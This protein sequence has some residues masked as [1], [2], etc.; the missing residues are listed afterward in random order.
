MLKMK[1]ELMFRCLSDLSSL[2]ESVQKDDVTDDVTADQR[3]VAEMVPASATHQATPST[4]R[5]YFAQL[6]GKK[7]LRSEKNEAILLHSFY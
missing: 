6:G 5:D 2:R 1:N 3:T 7:T 4:E